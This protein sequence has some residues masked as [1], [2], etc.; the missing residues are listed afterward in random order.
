MSV[1][2]T[3]CTPP[4]PPHAQLVKRITPYLYQCRLYRVT[5]LPH[6]DIDWSLV[7]SLVE[8]WQPDTHTFHLPTYEMSITLQ[9]IAILTRLPING[10]AVCGPTN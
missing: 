2:P 1:N 9:D 8:Q 10:N 4:P 3:I 5:Y 6:I 7:T